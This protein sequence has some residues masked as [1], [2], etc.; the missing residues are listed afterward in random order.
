M[1][2]PA[3]LSPCDIFVVEHANGSRAWMADLPRAVAERIAYRNGDAI[4]GNM[5]KP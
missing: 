5:M 4:F 2:Q 1:V 3:K